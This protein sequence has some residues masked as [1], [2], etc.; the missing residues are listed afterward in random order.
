M[1]KTEMGHTPVPVWRGGRPRPSCWACFPGVVFLGSQFFVAHRLCVFDGSIWRFAVVWVPEVKDDAVGLSRSL[2]DFLGLLRR[3]VKDLN[4]TRGD[5]SG[6]VVIEL[7]PVLEGNVRSRN[8]LGHKVF[9]LFERSIGFRGFIDEAFEHIARYGLAVMM[10]GP[11]DLTIH[12]VRCDHMNVV[13]F[14][15]GP[16]L[17]LWRCTSR[18]QGNDSGNQQRGEESVFVVHSFSSLSIVSKLMGN[19]REGKTNHAKNRMPALLA[20]QARIGAWRGRRNS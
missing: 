7:V 4:S 11:H 10:V 17:F 20:R 15:R 5:F 19:F 3:P 12:H 14:R 6:V 1:T 13:A 9:D 8:A 18:R 16:R 2:G